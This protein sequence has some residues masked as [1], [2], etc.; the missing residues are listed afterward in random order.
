VRLAVELELENHGSM[1]WTLAGAMLTGPREWKV[2]GVWT[3]EPIAPGETNPVM[4]E[5]E[6]TEASARGT[7]TLKLWGQEGGG[8]EVFE[9]VTFP[10]TA[11]R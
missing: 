7:F 1:P 10:D 6:V 4:V 2:L 11:L 8:S 3:R 9:G 5:V